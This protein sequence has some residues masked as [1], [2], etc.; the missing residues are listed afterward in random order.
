[1]SYSFITVPK[2]LLTFLLM[3]AICL[4][5]QQTHWSLNGTK[6][7]D[8]PSQI[9][10]TL[11]CRFVREGHRSYSPSIMPAVV[12]WWKIVTILILTLLWWFHSSVSAA[13][14]WWWGVRWDQMYCS[15]IFSDE[16]AVYLPGWHEGLFV[17][18]TALCLLEGHSF[19]EALELF[20]QF[21]HGGVNCCQH[22]QT[23]FGSFL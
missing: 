3:N 14:G 12:S 17:T 23:I 11:I 2:E 5:C 19:S 21:S 18:Q 16:A 8:I 9:R 13:E 1:M 6:L 7:G 22:Y 10:R 20:S 4:I 15:F